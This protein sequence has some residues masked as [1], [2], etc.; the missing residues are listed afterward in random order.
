M[1]PDSLL[2]ESIAYPETAVLP[3]WEDKLLTCI[4]HDRRAY[5]ASCLSDALAFVYRTLSYPYSPTGGERCC[6]STTRL[7][8][9]RGS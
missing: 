9:I 2:L 4:A 1:E 6:V 8:G 5:D 3:Y 7:F